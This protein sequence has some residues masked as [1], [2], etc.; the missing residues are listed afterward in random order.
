MVMSMITMIGLCC[1]CDLS[2]AF[3]GC[4]A[5]DEWSSGCSHAGA[6]IQKVNDNFGP[7]KSGLCSS[8]Y[9][10]FHDFW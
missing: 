7:L 8:F 5:C 10:P 2:D 6:H 9:D 3:P 4:T 1:Q